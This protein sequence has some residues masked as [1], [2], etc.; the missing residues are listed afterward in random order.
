M[1]DNESIVKLKLDAD[2][3]GGVQTE[4]QYDRLKAKVA[5]LGKDSSASVGKVTS[6]FGM[7]S[8]SI[9]LVKNVLAGFGAIGVISSL[10][11][12][13]KKVKDS[14]DSARK[15]A[16]AFR[17]AKEKAAHAKDVENL[18]EGYRK[19]A[20]QIK[21]VAD[22]ARHSSEM[23]DISVKSARDLEDAQLDLAEQQELDSVDDKDPAAQ[24]RRAA[25]SARYER[26]RR[27]AGATRAQQDVVYERQRLQMDADAKRKAAAGIEEAAGKSDSVIEDAK[28]RLA[29]ANWRS[30]A[31]NAEDS[32]GF[33]ERS[34][35]SIKD[36]FSGNWGKWA[37]ADFSTEAGDRL[38]DEAKAEA[39][40]LEAEIRRLE[41]QK[42]ARLKEAE[43]LRLEADRAEERKAAM[44][45]QISATGVRIA[46]AEIEGRRSSGSAGR[47]LDEKLSQIAA[48][49][50][51]VSTGGARMA[52]LSAAADREEARARAAADR[53]AAEQ[54]DV[55][56]AQ[57]RYD[58]LVANGGPRRDRSS[59]LAALQKEKEEALDAQHE[60]E[61]VAAEVANVLKA[62][63]EEVGALSRSVKSAQGRL[64]QNEADAPEG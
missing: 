49:E 25:I 21:A 37:R 5:Q 9:G 24:E 58:M 31:D 34:G 11:G 44:G 55:V 30:S 15:E 50:E 4:K 48:D 22:A 47:A 13:V 35:T 28:R 26:R 60:M 17:A 33:W 3:T 38:R 8:R 16:E 52:A 54:R 46:A 10:I 12:A 2:L 56:A 32:H 63:K 41:E 61:R 6:A 18:A 40:E 27:M 14:F 62:I 39:K 45:N 57:D 53:Y 20:E 64:K 36:F 19:L 51:T 7:L 42:E 29:D 59:A 43:A 23:L 1:A